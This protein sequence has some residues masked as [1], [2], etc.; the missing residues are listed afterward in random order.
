MSPEPEPGSRPAPDD[1]E[2]KLVMPELI[3][4][5]RA[6]REAIDTKKPEPTRTDEEVLRDVPEDAPAAEEIPR[7][8]RENLPGRSKL[9]EAFRRFKQRNPGRRSR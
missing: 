7:Q 5:A 9:S 2:G 1:L 6:Q 3:E 8:R 4:S